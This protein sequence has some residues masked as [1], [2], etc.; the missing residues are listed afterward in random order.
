M[1]F[2]RVE[3]AAVIVAIER[4][5]PDILR[6]FRFP[7]SRRRRIREKWRKRIGNYRMENIFRR[8]REYFPELT[9]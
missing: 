2:D 3:I 1:R 8:R 4:G 7:R 5:Q 9:Q 6:Q